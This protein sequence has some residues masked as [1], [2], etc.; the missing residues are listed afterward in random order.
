MIWCPFS[1]TLS[2]QWVQIPNK[3]KALRSLE[4]ADAFL[5]KSGPKAIL[6]TEKSK[7]DIITMIIVFAS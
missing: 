2:L 7:V 1:D 3:V 6:F 4:V 5:G